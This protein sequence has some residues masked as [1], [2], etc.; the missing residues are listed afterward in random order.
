M[1][2]YSQTRRKRLHIEK[3]ITTGGRYMKKTKTITDS[4]TKNSTNKNS[5]TSRLLENLQVRSISPA[6]NNF[7]F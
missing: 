7:Q 4:D 1:G 2:S 3:T 5:M 6:P